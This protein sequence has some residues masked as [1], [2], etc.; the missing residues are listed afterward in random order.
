MIWMTSKVGDSVYF[1][2]K[3]YAYPPTELWGMSLRTDHYL[4]GFPAKSGFYKTTTHCFE[5]KESSQQLMPNSLSYRKATV[6][7]ILG[8]FGPAPSPLV[9]LVTLLRAFVVIYEQ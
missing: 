2:K 3:T 7:N 8:I 9:Q 6:L 5:V 4:N 1:T